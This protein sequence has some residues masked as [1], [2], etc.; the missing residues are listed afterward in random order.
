MKKAFHSIRLKG[1]NVTGAGGV[2]EAK[3][4]TPETPVVT[5]EPVTF[6]H[7]W[8]NLI[9]PAGWYI[10][11]I[12]GNFEKEIIGW[13]K[14]PKYSGGSIMLMGHRGRYNH[15]KIRIGGL[16]TIA[17]AYPQ[18]QEQLKDMDR[19]RTE[20]G[21]FDARYELWKGW[22]SGTV[23]QSPM[24]IFK[25]RHC[26]VLMIGYVADKDG[27]EFEKDFKAI[28]HTLESTQ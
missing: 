12:P 3:V 8:V 5:G 10:D 1:E 22:V 6:S 17:A 26:W 28:Y 20:A 15:R 27:A 4:E 25:T 7:P 13:F 24:V 16:R 21:N 14:T 9:L 18:G 19:H 23:M 11:K 2:V